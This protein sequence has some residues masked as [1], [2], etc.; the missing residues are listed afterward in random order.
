MS[1]AL[2][3]T[4]ILLATLVLLGIGG[5]FFLRFSFAE[6]VIQQERQIQQKEQR[7]SQL[8]ATAD[9]FEQIQLMNITK[10]F[11]FENHPKELLSSN[12]V[13]DVYELLHTINR[14][15]A[16]TTM[17]FSLRDSVRNND[18]GILRVRLDGDGS[19]RAL[20][21]FLTILEQSKPIV[22]ITDIRIVPEGNTTE[23]LNRIR[24]ELHADFYYARGGTTTDPE[25]LIRTSVPR[26]LYNPFF[27]LVH[28]VPANTDNLIDVERSR[29]VGLV[30]GGAY[31][32]DQSGELR[33]VP[34]GSRVYLGSLIRVNMNEQTAA[35]RLNRGGIRDDVVLRI[36][37]SE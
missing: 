15:A 1:Y 7:L 9:T 10:R 33:F 20:F 8:S 2:R 22:R 14:G 24:Y 30:R 6:D 37:E 26:R 17:N 34:I 36:N 31:L 35:F 23:S 3:N 5:W 16:F 21:N 4:L 29:L 13:A 11:E 19:Y 25:M 28:E 18:H 27:A 12:N 32:I